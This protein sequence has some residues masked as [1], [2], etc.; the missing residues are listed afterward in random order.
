[1]TWPCNDFF[2]PVPEQRSDFFLGLDL[3]QPGEFTALAVVERITS[4]QPTRY[5][6]RHLQ[7]WTIGT[8]FPQIVIDVAERMAAREHGQPMMPGATLIVDGTGVGR[9]VV[10]LFKHLPGSLE[11]FSRVQITPGHAVAFDATSGA[12]HVARKELAG[13]LQAMLQTRRLQIVSSPEAEMLAKE[14]LAFRAKV[15]AP[16]ADALVFWRERPQ[17]DVALALAIALWYAERHPVV[18]MAQGP[19]VLTPGRQEW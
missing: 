16:D 10:D 1:M 14:L 6:C 17:D 18:L 4:R 3:A 13:V 19:C 2:S 12:W 7:R 9:A 8:P 11:R 15:T 5:T